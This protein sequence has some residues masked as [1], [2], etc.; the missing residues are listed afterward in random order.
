MSRHLECGLAAWVVV[1][2]VLWQAEADAAVD[3][4]TGL[5][6]LPST[7]EVATRGVRLAAGHAALHVTY[8]R[9]VL[10]S[11]VDR[12][13]VERVDHQRGAVPV[14]LWRLRPSGRQALRDVVADCLAPVVR[15]T[16]PPPPPRRR[17]RRL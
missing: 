7:T 4:V 11:L 6:G 2:G 16:P 5:E 12:G 10:D 1:L 15:L 13:H 8:V 9:R 14:L 3:G 17:R